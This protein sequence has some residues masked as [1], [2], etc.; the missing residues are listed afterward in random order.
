MSFPISLP[1]LYPSAPHLHTEQALKKLRIDIFTPKTGFL[2]RNHSMRFSYECSHNPYLAMFLLVKMQCGKQI[3]G[4]WGQLSPPQLADS[5]WAL[6]TSCCHLPVLFQ[7]WQ[8]HSEPELLGHLNYVQQAWGLQQWRSA[9]PR[10]PTAHT[11]AYQSVLSLSWD[12]I[13]PQPLTVQAHALHPSPTK[14]GWQVILE[15]T[16]MLLTAHVL[17]HAGWVIF[18]F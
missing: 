5:F 7:K 16:A 18:F 6:H 3:T 14:R 4:S 2:Q 15:Q 13:W 12:F 17:E 1:L 11:S 8:P 9:L 10:Q